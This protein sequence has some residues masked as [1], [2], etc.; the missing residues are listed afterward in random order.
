MSS[1]ACRYAL[2]VGDHPAVDDVGQAAFQAPHRFHACL[3]VGQSALVVGAAGGVVTELDNG[4][5]VQHSVDPA[6]SRPRQPVP[7]T[8]TRRCLQRSCAV[9]GRE[10]ALVG[11]SADI[12]NVA[13]HN[14]AVGRIYGAWLGADHILDGDP[15][16]VATGWR[17]R[18]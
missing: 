3:A 8:I 6:V 9:P 10:P 18:R 7:T 2:G 16:Y 12:T 17:L 1:R 15:F 4:H 13:E 5:H 11:E 14:E